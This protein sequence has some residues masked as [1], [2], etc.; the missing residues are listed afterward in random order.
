[1]PSNIDPT[2]SRALAGR[3]LFVISNRQELLAI[4]MMDNPKAAHKVQLP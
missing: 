4:T 1:M 3:T 2:E